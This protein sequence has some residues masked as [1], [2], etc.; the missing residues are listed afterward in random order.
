M[1][2]YE[3]IYHPQVQ[4]ID[5]T[6]AMSDPQVL[7]ELGEM[8]SLL[9]LL[10]AESDNPVLIELGQLYKQDPNLIIEDARV[11][12]LVDHLEAQ[13]GKF[14]PDNSFPMQLKSTSEIL[15]PEL[16][17]GS[18]SNSIASHLAFIYQ[19]IK[20]NHSL[21]EVMHGYTRGTKRVG[22]LDR[23]NG[24]FDKDCNRIPF[25]LVGQ[26][27]E[28]LEEKIN[29][30]I[31]K[32]LE[33]EGKPT[34]G[35]AYIAKLQELVKMTP[36]QL[37]VIRQSYNQR[38]MIGAGTAFLNTDKFP[39]PSTDN[40]EDILHVIDKKGKLTLQSIEYREEIKADKMEDGLPVLD[41]ND[42]KIKV[43]LYAISY[44]LCFKKNAPV[45][46]IITT[47]SLSPDGE[48]DLPQCLKN[49]ELNNI[50]EKAIDQNNQ[51][52]IKEIFAVAPL[53]AQDK[54]IAT[55][56]NA[57]IKKEKTTD[58]KISIADLTTKIQKNILENIIGEQ[59][60]PKN[61]ALLNQGI[62]N[63]ITHENPSV[64]TKLVQ[65]VKALRDS[66]LH[67]KFISR[68]EY[69][70]D[71]IDRQID[72]LTGT[73]KASHLEVNFLSEDPKIQHHEVRGNSK[74]TLTH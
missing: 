48:I 66:I 35:A 15:N 20:N 19:S 52:K 13:L 27:G 12:K 55:F 42:E 17:F 50:L 36:E 32:E 59:L 67:A 61:A 49:R 43:P 69:Q 44:K 10:L 2:N 53:E 22:L 38:Y 23:L 39:S 62:N 8:K 46:K 57:Q 68:E 74:S 7:S 70:K 60:E 6:G 9:R 64:L 34:N 18:S 30:R 28:I 1:T 11:Q 3:T 47:T 25:K 54:L 37:D 24:Q 26:H 41:V 5:L 56:V 14:N 45:E 65:Q 40:R 72:K 58:P 73:L 63:Y 4:A 33:A 71:K 16:D 29:A 31:V 51:K 21:T